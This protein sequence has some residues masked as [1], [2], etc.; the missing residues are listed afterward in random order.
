M[1]KITSFLSRFNTEYF[2]SVPAETM[3]VWFWLGFYILLI[4]IFSFIYFIIYKR[5]KIDKPMSK[6]GTSYIWINGGLVF[7]GLFFWWFRFE[8]FSSLSWRA[9]HYLVILALIGYNFYFFYFEK[10]KIKAEVASFRN[11]QRKEK[12]LNKKKKK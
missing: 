11:I 3:M 2:F 5:S 1:T 9:W 6:H 4:Y 7:V 12:W 10:K 8:H